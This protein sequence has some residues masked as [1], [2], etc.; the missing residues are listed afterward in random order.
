MRA[1]A[2]KMQIYRGMSG[3]RIPRSTDS[4][5]HLRNCM[6]WR[7]LDL[8]WL[9][10]G[11]EVC[12]EKSPIGCWNAILLLSLCCSV[13][14]CWK[15]WA[16][17]ILA[18]GVVRR[19]EKLWNVPSLPPLL[20]LPQHLPVLLQLEW[21]RITSD[22]QSQLLLCIQASPCF[23]EPSQWSAI[24]LGWQP[25]TPFSIFYVL[26]LSHKSLTEIRLIAVTQY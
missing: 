20:P 3:T 25:C 10:E 19:R 6:L 12:E 13:T 4:W 21:K 24:M 15:Y 26:Y 1:E 17:T 9:V 5:I 14:C 2:W 16:G 18:K 11:E 8:A 22:R 23:A 7:C